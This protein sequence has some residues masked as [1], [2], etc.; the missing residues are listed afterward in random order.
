VK[1]ITFYMN[2]ASNKFVL[3]IFYI[4]LILSGCVHYN[5]DKESEY[6]LR[7]SSELIKNKRFVESLRFLTKAERVKKYRAI[8][9]YESAQIFELLNQFVAAEELYKKADF[10]SK[11][12]E[13]SFRKDHILKNTQE[14]IKR[15][16]NAHFCSIEK[17][18]TLIKLN[19]VATFVYLFI[20]G[21]DY[22]KYKYI[23]SNTYNDKFS[24]TKNTYI[25]GVVTIKDKRG[26]YFQF[27]SADKCPTRKYKNLDIFWINI[28]DIVSIT[29]L[30]KD[31]IYNFANKL[32]MTAN[33]SWIL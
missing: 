7:K 19:T 23:E 6:Y 30:D 32:T 5:I 24:K 33:D 25:S 20:S 27:V 8:S 29:I 18:P 3:Y 9:C 11:K 31:N 28:N 14:R 4:I 12:I 22:S 1:G 15:C 17:E 21:K 2:H 26:S 10:Y 16:I 13:K